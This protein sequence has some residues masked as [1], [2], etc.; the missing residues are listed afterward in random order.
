MPKTVYQV[1]EIELQD[2]SVATLRPLN[3]KAMKAFQKTL[4]GLKTAETDE[5]ATDIFVDLTAICLAKELP[6][7][8]ADR[9]ALEEALDIETI[10]RVLE[11][12]GGLK[13]N[14]ENLIQ[15]AIMSQA[16]AGLS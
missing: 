15:A 11:I 8:V 5:Q 2:G 12:C 13:L 7:L 16:Q 3:I 9:D 1:E 14:D 6:D 10:Y 4:E